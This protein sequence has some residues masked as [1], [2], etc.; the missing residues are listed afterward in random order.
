MKIAK[1]EKSKHKQERVLV[2]LEGGDLLRITGSELLRFGLYPGMDLSDD[3]VV[4]L[5]NA[6]AR[7]ETRATAARIASSR[8]L[9]KKE[10]VGR[11]TKRGVDAEEAAGTADWLEDLGA[12][13]DAAY[14]GVVVRHYAAMGYGAGR[15]R[16]ELFR[17]GIPR[18]LWDGAL[19]QMPPAEEAIEHFLRSKLKGRPLDQTAQRKLSAALQR[20]G[21]SWGEIRPVLNR[22]GETEIEE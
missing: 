3:L 8:M 2:F 18:E 15:V 9:S 20:R 17:R 1:I 7:S 6:A 5:K 21:F 11:L 4:E 10:L 16:Q 12:V 13:D 19:E 22:L 14:A